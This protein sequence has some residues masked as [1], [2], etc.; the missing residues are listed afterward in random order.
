MKD[1]LEETAARRAKLAA[2]AKKAELEMQ[3]AAAEKDREKRQLRKDASEHDLYE[4]NERMKQRL[5]A[6]SSRVK[7]RDVAEV[8]AKINAF[9]LRLKEEKY[10]K[11]ATRTQQAIIRELHRR[12][13]T[14]KISAPKHVAD[15][16]FKASFASRLELKNLPLSQH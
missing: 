1:R 13:S 7:T 10:R 2:D 8:D 11:H 3:E 4:S 15:K 6:M 14:G 12:C 9:K 5:K 16:W